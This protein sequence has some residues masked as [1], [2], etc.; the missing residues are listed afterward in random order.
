MKRIKNLWANCCSALRTKWLTLLRTKW[1]QQ[2][3]ALIFRLSRPDA[4]LHLA[5]F[6]LI[7]GFLAGGVI[8]VFR[9]LV[10][11][12]QG[13]ML[14]GDNPENYEAISPYWHF[15]LACYL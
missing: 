2:L 10:E 15:F 5:F 1:Q 8:V 9:L 13:Y 14:P 4:L 3:E 7:A 12:T 6:G 11:K